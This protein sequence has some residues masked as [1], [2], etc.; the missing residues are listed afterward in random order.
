MKFIEFIDRWK[1]GCERK[2]KSFKYLRENIGYD[3][4][5]FFREMLV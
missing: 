3:R 2:K 1:M 5:D 4:I